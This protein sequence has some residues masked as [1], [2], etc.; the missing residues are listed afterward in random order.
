MYDLWYILCKSEERFL[1]KEL[2]PLF[3]EKCRVRGVQPDI[4]SLTS[5]TLREWNENVWLNRLGPMLKDVPDFDRVWKV[6]V[7]TFH[8]LIKDAK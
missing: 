5:D 2:K 1:W 8:D 3:D 7:K 6:W 4:E